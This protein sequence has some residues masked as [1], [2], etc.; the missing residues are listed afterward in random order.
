MAVVIHD[1]A[2]LAG[3][4]TTIYPVAFAA[5]LKGR[6]KRALGDAGG[7]TQF[8]VNLT[9]LEPGAISALRHWHSREDEFVYVL[10]G[11]LTLIADEGE[12]LLGP[13]VAV[14]FPAGE[15]NAHQLAQPKRSGGH[16]SGDRHARGRRRDHLPGRRFAAR[17][18]GQPA[19]LRAQV[20]RALRMSMAGALLKAPIHL[21]RWTLKPYVGWNCRHLPTCSDYA[22]RP[23]DKNG[24]WR[25]FWLTLSRL[26]R[27]HPYGTRGLRP[28]AGHHG[29][30]AHLGRP[31]VTAG[32]AGPIDRSPIDRSETRCSGPMRA[33]SCR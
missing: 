12:E 6:I 13:G 22:S 27:C 15:A 10:S 32:G 33:S 2:G 25:G 21:Y 3:R 23:I 9:T 7:L 26:S 4:R 16:L 30:A 19:P 8:G 5:G 20:R 29:R 17:E 14:A 28:G 18:A 24:A 31:G 11:E 1:P